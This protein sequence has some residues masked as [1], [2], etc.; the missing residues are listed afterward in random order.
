V[1]GDPSNDDI[2]GTVFEHDPLLV[3]PPS[4]PSPKIRFNNTHY[5]HKANPPLQANATPSWRRSSR[6]CRQLRLYP[7]HGYQGNLY[8]WHHFHQ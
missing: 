1:N 5:H 7:G 2:N 6:T 3:T 4:Q 8:R